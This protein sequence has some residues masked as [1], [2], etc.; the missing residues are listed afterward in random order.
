[1]K[2]LPRTKLTNVTSHSSRFNPALEDLL[3]QAPL[4][5]PSFLSS[6][7]MGDVGAGEAPVVSSAEGPVV[8][9]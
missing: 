5:L 3:F 4:S 1:M 9:G 7:E 2:V 6:N 8:K